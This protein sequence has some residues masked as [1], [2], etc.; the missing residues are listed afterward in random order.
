ML[1]KAI[2]SLDQF[3]VKSETER[4]YMP[5]LLVFMVCSIV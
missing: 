5:Y 1:K 3:S 4:K 2:T